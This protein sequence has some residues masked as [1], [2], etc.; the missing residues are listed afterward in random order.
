MS[1]SM[2]IG[3]SAPKLP[4]DA[5]TQTFG[6]IGRKGS[7]KTY[8]A[9]VLVEEMHGAGG[10][11][12]VIDPLG[13]W[14]GLR[15][16]AKGKAGGLNIPI[17][18]G[19]H[20]D[21]PLVETAGALVAELVVGEGISAILD[22]SPFSKAA[23]RRFYT[24]FATALFQLKKKKRTPVHLVL[25]EAHLFAPQRSAGEE[26]MLG[27]S[28]DLVR[29]GRNVGIGVS[30]LDQ[31]P[32]S[33]NKEVLNQVECL[34]VFQITG[35]HERKAIKEWVV[36]AGA[37]VVDLIDQLPGLHIGT[38]Y[39]W[40]PQWLGLLERVKIRPKRTYDASS[41]PTVGHD[42]PAEQRG[43]AEIN[44]PAISA[45]M[46]ALV[47]DK[48]GSDP[49]ALKKR[50]RELE[51]QLAAKEWPSAAPAGHS[52][53]EVAALIEKAERTSRR[54]LASAI[55]GGLRPVLDQLDAIALSPSEDP[56]RVVVPKSKADPP[57]KPRAPRPSAAPKAREGLSKPMSK[58]LDAV[59]RYA[60]F[61][62]LSP[63]AGQVAVMAGYSPGA[64]HFNN[65]VGQL[66]TSGHVVRDNGAIR[67]AEGIEIAAAPPT[68]EDLHEQIRGLR[69]LGGPHRKVLDYIIG[70]GD[71]EIRVDEI[72]IATGY[73]PGTGHF[74]N[75]IGRLSTLGLVD[76]PRSGFVRPTEILFPKGL[77]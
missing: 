20:G 58:V 37:D 31:R 56:E 66:V 10:Q 29:L 44:L 6:L 41:T 47:E 67:L 17:F 16:G 13:N 43:L 3:A 7:G 36:H 22:V 72:A 75:T 68:L 71:I 23:R 60:R 19:D 9:G 49:N 28:E 77:A 52:D 69:S 40:S 73:A 70:Q 24:D 33:V 30:M 74:N 39:L 5:I 32:Q 53:E 50:I 38:C 21:V 11:V 65:T 26:K 1:L 18:G 46:E 8:A 51:K 62:L 4:A 61:G 35:S 14:Y 54:A 45:A 34:L 25:E 27:A 48:R 2:F 59:A 12:V 42:A 57:E 15:L 63:S 76:R 55:R 64:G